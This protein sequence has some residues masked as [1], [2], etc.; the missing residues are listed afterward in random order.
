[1]NRQAGARNHE[2]YRKR[3]QSVN[4]EKGKSGKKGNENNGMKTKRLCLFFYI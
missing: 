3:E 1:V 2:E 4:E